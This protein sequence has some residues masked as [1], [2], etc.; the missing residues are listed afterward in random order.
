V[1]EPVVR[2][3]LDD[4]PSRRAH[5]RAR[6]VRRRARGGV[7]RHAGRAAADPVHLRARLPALRPLARRARRSQGRA[8]ARARRPPR[9]GR[10][11]AARQARHG[12]HAR[13]RTLRPRPVADVRVF[14]GH[15][16]VKTTSLYLASG[17]DRQEHVV[18]LRE[19]GRPTIARPHER[20]VGAG[21]GLPAGLREGRAQPGPPGGAAGRH[22]LACRGR[23]WQREQAA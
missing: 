18:R 9:Q 11:P 17:E 8:T 20:R 16:S 15:A 2:R 4:L 1:R 3:V 21:A 22:A 10:P 5:R 12:R 7:R 6:R 23:D 19:R 13:D 14:L